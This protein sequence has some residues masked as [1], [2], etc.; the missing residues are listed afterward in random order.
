[1]VYVYLL[2]SILIFN[3]DN[4]CS[5]LTDPEKIDKLYSKLCRNHGFC[6]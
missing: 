4:F 2:V 3:T 5:R 6:L 1:M